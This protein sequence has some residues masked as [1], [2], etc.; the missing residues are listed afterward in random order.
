MLMMDYKSQYTASVIGSDTLSDSAASRQ[1][2]R[3]RTIRL[4][5]PNYGALPTT[6]LTCRHGPNLGF[7]IR[8]GREH[9][10]G[11]F[12]SQIELGSVA[13]RQGLRIGDQI[14][15]VNGF[16]VDDAIHKEVLQLIS[17]FVHVSLKV[18][19]VGMIPVKDKHTDPLSWQ[20]ISECNSSTRSSPQ[21]GEKNQDVMINILVS[22]RSKLGCGICKGPEWKPGIFI[23]FTRE[24]GVSR[25][26]GLRPGDQILFCNNVDFTDISFSE[27]IHIMKASHKLDLIVRKS[28][29][30]ELFPGES[31]GYNSSASSV[32][33][34]QSPSWSE[35]KRLSIV[36]EESLVLED[37]LTN[38]ER[39]KC[40]KWEKMEWEDLEVEDK[41]Y[42]KPTIINLSEYGTT[43]KN[44]G[45][46]SSSLNLIENSNK[47]AGMNLV[48]NQ[49]EIKTTI[50]GLYEEQ[51]KNKTNKLSKT[52]SVSSLTSMQSTTTSLSS[53]IS[54]E[55]QRRSEKN[56]NKNKEASIDDKMQINK[57][58]RT[59]NSEKQQQHNK[60]MDEFKKAHRKMFKSCE[61]LETESNSPTDLDRSENIKIT[62]R[63]TS[64]TTETLQTKPLTLTRNAGSACILPPPPPPPLP[65]Y[66]CQDKN[67]ESVIEKEK[68]KVPPPVPAKTS[69]LSFYQPPPCPT[70]DYDSLSIDSNINIAK[71]TFEQCRKSNKIA[72][73]DTVEMVSIESSK[74]NNTVHNK[75]I[76]PNPCF[77]N[78]VQ[79]VSLKTTNEAK[80]V[81]VT[82]GEYP[83]GSTRKVPRKF[84]F[85][86][87]G[88]DKIDKA[89]EQPITS[90]LASELVQTLNRSNLKKKT[91]TTVNI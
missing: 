54:Q 2:S 7:S 23:Q 63:L 87:N 48:P 28:A 74:M 36:K 34:D 31:S 88:K 84:E 61:N 44:N 53:A 50:N 90:K 9:G 38:L 35:S 69:T 65:T 89:K 1:P 24:G 68:H 11:F 3:I 30:S 26:A 85:L 18:R 33:G 55:L 66:N 15:R 29:G 47:Y 71:N 56:R 32:T 57:M 78:A 22:P 5:R 79:M 72:N 14:I 62:D 52:P 86:Q 6:G 13:H 59:S 51:S 4:V 10:T 82:I 80:S 39:L 77:A 75:P 20:I 16:T 76:L 73:N 25:E 45:S 64:F 58:L 83:T 42:Y 12:V 27:A 19:S 21:L 46:Q 70:P 8:G 37:R 91:E 43:I 81:S 41:F 17:N 60:L 49:H 40:K 67:D